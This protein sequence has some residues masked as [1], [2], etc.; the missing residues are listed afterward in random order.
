MIYIDMLQKKK[1]VPQFSIF[2]D[3][4]LCE[5]NKSTIK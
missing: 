2:S 1:D 5:K 4:I 3:T